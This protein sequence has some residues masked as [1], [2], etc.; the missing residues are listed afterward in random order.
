MEERECVGEAGEER[1]LGKVMGGGGKGVCF[2]HC[3]R[4]G[5]ADPGMMCFGCVPNIEVCRYV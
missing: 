1:L 3:V 5:T 4:M 2:E